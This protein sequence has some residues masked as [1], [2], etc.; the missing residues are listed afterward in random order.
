MDSQSNEDQ[1]RNKYKSDEGI[2]YVKSEE[3]EQKMK[4]VSNQYNDMSEVIQE[5]VLSSEAMPA[6]TRDLNANGQESNMTWMTENIKLETR[7]MRLEIQEDWNETTTELKQIPGAEIMLVNSANFCPSTGRQESDLEDDNE[8]GSAS[9]H[10]EKKTLRQILLDLETKRGQ[11]TTEDNKVA[12]NTNIR[13]TEIARNSTAAASPTCPKI[14]VSTAMH[15]DQKVSSSSFAEQVRAPT[16]RHC[17]G[18]QRELAPPSKNIEAGSDFIGNHCLPPGRPP[19]RESAAALGTARPAVNGRN[20]DAVSQDIANEE[21]TGSAYLREDRTYM[22]RNRQTAP[23]LDF[24]AELAALKR[25][26]L[27]VNSIVTEDIVRTAPV[28][29]QGTA[30]SPE[31]ITALYPAL[32]RNVS[33]LEDRPEGG[34]QSI[35]KTV[36]V[37][38]ASTE[39]RVAGSTDNRAECK[40]MFLWPPKETMAQTQVVNEELAAMHEKLMAQ[41]DL[42]NTAGPVPEERTG[43]DRSQTLMERGNDKA[44]TDKRLHVASEIGQDACQVERMGSNSREQAYTDIDRDRAPGST[45]HVEVKRYGELA[46]AAEPAESGA[47]V[48]DRS[49]RLPEMGDGR[50]SIEEQ[51]TKMQATKEVGLEQYRMEEGKKDAGLGAATAKGRHSDSEGTV[52]KAL[53]TQDRQTHVLEGTSNSTRRQCKVIREKRIRVEMSTV[54]LEGP[55]SNRIDRWSEE[56]HDGGLGLTT[57]HVTWK[58]KRGLV[59]NHIGS[60]RRRK[61]GKARFA[62]GRW[63]TD[64]AN[65]TSQ[66]H[67]QQ[68]EVTDLLPGQRQHTTSQTVGNS[69]QCGEADRENALALMTDGREMIM[70]SVSRLARL[71]AALPPTL[72]Q[73][74]E[75]EGGQVTAEETEQMALGRLRLSGTYRSCPLSIEVDRDAW[76]AWP[77]HERG[78][79]SMVVRDAVRKRCPKGSGFAPL[80]VKWSVDGKRLSRAQEPRTFEDLAA[81]VEQ[82]VSFEVT[83]GLLGGADNGNVAQAALTTELEF[84]APADYQELDRA[85]HGVMAGEQTLETGSVQLARRLLSTIRPGDWSLVSGLVA[86][87]GLLTPGRILVLG[88]VV[89]RNAGHLLSIH[90]PGW[91][92]T[93]NLMSLRFCDIQPSA[94]GWKGQGGMATAKVL[95]ASAILGIPGLVDAVNYDWQTLRTSIRVEGDMTSTDGLWSATAV[96][97][98]GPWIAQL[99]TGQMSISPAAYTVLAPHSTYVEVNL[100]AQTSNILKGIGKILQLEGNLLRGMIREA[101]QRALGADMCLIR[102]TTSLFTPGSDGKKPKSSFFPPDHADSQIVLGVEAT[103]LI[104]ALRKAPQMRIEL[105]YPPGLPV[106]ITLPCPQVPGYALEAMRR[107]RG[108]AAVRLRQPGARPT[109][110]DVMLGYQGAGIDLVQSGA[111]LPTGWLSEA[112]INSAADKLWALQLLRLGFQTH[113]GAVNMLPVGRLKKRGG[114]PAYL[115]LMFETVEAAA[116][117]CDAVDQAALPPPLTS[118]LQEFLD[119]NSG[120]LVTFSS[121]IAP[122]AIEGCPEKEIVA[123]FKVG[124]TEDACI[125]PRPHAPT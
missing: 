55:V 125:A 33:V 96:L 51:C 14:L 62:G 78:D 100:D 82:E 6:T 93:A 45:M 114:D 110:R 23:G 102:I 28:A 31:I 15:A 77:E 83:V 98:Q 94:M 1:A 71:K 91:V 89:R 61:A 9:R 85:V 32:E 120:R 118:A 79:A 104:Q 44:G 121:S 66:R 46:A 29:K 8:R 22:V 76:Q 84:M 52:D 16:A 25:R 53:M 54:G 3:E 105:G 73:A 11:G 26:S 35:G 37:G 57:K 117:F 18:L 56:M 20:A 124:M 90:F 17:H 87:G 59:S 41:G 7:P 39:W 88:E 112:L 60:L 4:K 86:D 68:S 12:Q 119:L 95:M 36:K 103:Y 30:Y 5:Q 49:P 111:H 122:E 107:A 75:P 58:G 63:G 40:P 21:R 72:Q 19:S 34:T 2:K 27:P 101:L 69:R 108:I 24:A 47:K 99:L 43:R 67:L 80:H 50:P 97:P 116:T 123:L 74:K 81:L 64:A 92:S 70:G 113:V 48:G 42:E 115:A 109:T 65:S 106:T 10:T 38:M 13:Y